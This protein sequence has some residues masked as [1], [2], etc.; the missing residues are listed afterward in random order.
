MP[1]AAG[2]G[3]AIRYR[4]EDAVCLCLFGDSVLNIGAFHEGFNMAAKWGLPVVFVCENNSY[5]MGT[6]IERVA[7]IEE[8]VDRACA[9][10]GMGSGAVDGMDVMAVR[11]ATDEAVRVAREEGRPYFLEAR[12]Y[13][14]MGHSMADPAHGTYRSKD[15]VDEERENDPILSYLERLEAAGIVSQEEYDATVNEVEVLRA[16]LERSGDIEQ[17]GADGQWVSGDDFVPMLEPAQGDAGCLAFLF[18]Q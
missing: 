5:G 2:V 10:E 3:Y 16:E 15:E 11:E 8:L 12:C 17:R 13:R 9:Y 1:I 14:Y 7:A 18:D 6:D 4:E